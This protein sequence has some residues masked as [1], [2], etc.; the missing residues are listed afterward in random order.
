MEK[1]KCDAIQYKY[2]AKVCQKWYNVC[3]LAKH[4]YN[5]PNIIINRN[6]VKL[7]LIMCI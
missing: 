6:V 5:G 2:V 4:T 3:K 7:F 1:P